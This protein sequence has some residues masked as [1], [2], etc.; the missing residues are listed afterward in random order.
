M[1]ELMS[2]E[3]LAHLEWADAQITDE[4]LGD[5]SLPLA[6]HDRR[7]LIAEVKRLN[8]ALTEARDLAK[9]ALGILYQFPTDIADFDA[10]LDSDRL[11]Q[12]ADGEAETW[13]RD[14]EDGA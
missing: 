9:L 8:E 14:T 13:R 6:F 3:R 1:A 4:M 11:P 5:G 12:W 2:P 7:E 10:S